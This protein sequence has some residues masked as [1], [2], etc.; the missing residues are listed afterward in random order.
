MFFFEKKK[1]PFCIYI[2][3][4]IFVNTFSFKYLWERKNIFEYTFSFEN[5][6]II[7]WKIIHLSIDYH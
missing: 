3:N 2:V 1:K 6:Y 4:E 7:F 5:L